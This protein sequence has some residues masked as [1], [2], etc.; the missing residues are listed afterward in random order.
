MATFELTASQRDMTI[1]LSELRSDRLIPCVV[2]GSGTEN[3]HLTLPYSDFL[4]MYRKTGKSNII[5]LIV[6][7]KKID[8][9]VG[10]V[11]VHP[12]S[13]NFLHLDFQVVKKGEKLNTTI[14]LTLTGEAPAA[15]EGALIDQSLFSL[16]ITCLPKDLVDHF[17]V[18]L[19]L[20]KTTGD[21]VH[22]ADIGLDTT[23]Y[24]IS[25][26]DSTP[27]VAAHIVRAQKTT[28][29]ES[30]EAAEGAPAPAAE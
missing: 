8:V 24:E 2:Y 23:K 26:D 9:L 11:Q 29:E 12:V 10:E 6:D 1:K 28:D 21:I 25:I 7:K 14:P 17:D 15:K 16:D 19:G 22:I 20:L 4:R 3:M 30:G 18:D 27:I 5:T 13:D